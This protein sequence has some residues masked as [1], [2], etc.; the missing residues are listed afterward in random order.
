[1]EP[2]RPHRHR[3]AQ[4]WPQENDMTFDVHVRERILRPVQRVFAA[5]VDPEEMTHYFISKG[6]GRLEA[7]KDITW[8]FADV[9]TSVKIHVLEVIADE[10]IVY[11][12]KAL[13]D[14]IRTTIRFK[15]DGADATVVTITDSSFPLT[16]EGVKRALGQNAG[17]T[18][19]LCA[20][21]A[22]LQFGVNLRAGLDKRIT[23]VG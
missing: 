23:D 15:A 3:P 22:Y 1:V 14:L 17:W 12:S 16:D 4:D 18:Y 20:L 9:G 8:E 7:G 19:T 6:S 13:G 10:R 21:K 5:V 11:Q 2:T